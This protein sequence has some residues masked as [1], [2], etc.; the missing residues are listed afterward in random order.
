MIRQGGFSLLELLVAVA[1]F[2]AVSAVAYGGLSSVLKTRQQTEQYMARLQALQHTLS[3]LQR[4]ITQAVPR[5]VRDP[6]GEKQ[7]AL[8]QPADRLLALTRTG[9][10]NP[11]GLK[12]SGLRRVAYALEEDK[13]V[14]YLWGVL[15]PP[16]GVEPYRVVMLEGVRNVEIR[17]V[18]QQREWQNQW[19]VLSAEDAGTESD[20]PLAIEV[21][22]DL[23]RWGEFRRLIPLVEEP[24]TV[25][26]S[27]KAEGQ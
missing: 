24:V 20:I 25:D 6:Y 1:V 22:L 17:F 19:P 18:D 4:D 5:P 10:P 12:R 13:L 21:T 27:N 3:A 26:G 23:E 7:P 9:R 15:D 11:L 8:Y 16:Q 14:R 2:A